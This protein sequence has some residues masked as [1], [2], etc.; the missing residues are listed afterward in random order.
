MK[1]TK[2]GNRFYITGILALDKAYSDLAT[3]KQQKQVLL[4]C[5]LDREAHVVQQR[6]DHQ[7]DIIADL[8]VAVMKQRAELVRHMLLAFAAADIATTAAD[9]LAEAFDEHTVGYDNKGG[10]A[11]AD[12]IRNQANEW[13]EC[14]QM[15]DGDG[16]SGNERVSM[17]YSDIAEEIVAKVIPDVLEII[18]RHMATEKGKRLL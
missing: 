6:I 14:V 15:I 3:M 11:L 13:N 4:D 10:K 12:I 17:Y 5:G 16:V 1:R 2:R 7:H 18:D 9:K 8:K